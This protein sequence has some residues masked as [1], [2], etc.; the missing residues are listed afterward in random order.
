MAAP[1][2]LISLDS[3][4]ECGLS[5]PMS[6]SLW[7]YSYS[8]LVIPVVLAEVPFVHVD[9]LVAP[10]ADSKFDLAKQRPERHESFIVHDVMVSR[11]R[12]RVASR[13]SSPPGSSSSDTFAPLSEFVVALVLLTMRK[14]VGP[15]LARRRAWRRVSHRSSDRY[16]SLDSTSDS[17]S[18]SSSLG[19]SSHTSSCSPSD[20]LSVHHQS[21]EDSK[22]EHM[23]IGTADTE[24]VAD[25]GIVAGVGAP[26]EDGIGMGVEVAATDIKEDE[27]EFEAEARAGG[28]MEVVVDILVIGGIF[29]STGED[30]PDI[31]EEF[32]QI[33]RDRDD[34]RRRLKRNMT[35]TRSG[36]TPTTIKEM[37]NRRVIESLEARKANKNIG[38]WNSNDEGGNG[39]NEMSTT[40]LKGNEGVFGLIRWFEKMEI[41][42]HINNFLEKYQVRYATCN[43]LN[44]ALTWWNSHKRTIGTDAA[45]SMSW[46]ELIKLMAEVYCPRNEIQKMKSELWN[47]TGNVIDAEPTRLQD[48]ICMADNLM[49]Q[50]LK[51]YAMK[52]AKN[53]RSHYASVLFDLGV[54]QSFV[55]TTYITLLDIFLDTLDV[56]YAVEL[57]DGRISETNTMLRANHHTMIICDEKIVRIPYGDEVLIVQDARIKCLIEDQF[58]VSFSPT[59]SS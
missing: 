26:T 11:Q 9:P 36:M 23:E 47:L 6:D 46:R 25:L 42:F 58:E 40:K 14:R 1:V 41:V 52:N 15:F 19:S 17:S 16:S 32:R 50:M 44:S 59:Q 43:L 18:S 21:P 20:S 30:A 10:E 39:L 8:I 12:S 28:T 29:E 56:S 2:I 33:C 49:D 57:A 35:N 38:L 4:K 37:I 53:K 27:E 48:A 34:A 5:C 54:D 55:S 24:A 13:P 3:S 51:G 31:K 7:H 22:E 45:F